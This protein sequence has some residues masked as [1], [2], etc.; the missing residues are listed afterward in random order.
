ML[1]QRVAGLLL[2]LGTVQVVDLPSTVTCSIGSR[3]CTLNT[4]PV[5]LWQS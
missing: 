4:L 2:S 3:A 1:S 5:R